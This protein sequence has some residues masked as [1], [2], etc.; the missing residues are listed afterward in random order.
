MNTQLDR[1]ATGNMVAESPRRAV[2][3]R[4]KIEAAGAGQKV[5][6]AVVAETETTAITLA[7]AVA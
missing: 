4:T 2:A 5:V 1:A 7:A 6:A 3:A